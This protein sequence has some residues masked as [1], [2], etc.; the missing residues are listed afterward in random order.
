MRAS[1]PAN[2]DGN[3]FTVTVQNQKQQELMEANR[4]D[5]LEKIHNALA[6]DLITFD[7]VI[8]QGSDPRHTLNENELLQRMTAE[9]PALQHLITDLKLRLS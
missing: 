1:Y 7:V 4:P 8:A 6:N 2:I 5:I 3:R 9:Y